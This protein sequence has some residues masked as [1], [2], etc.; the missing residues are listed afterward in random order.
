MFFNQING[1]GF[2][3]FLSVIFRYGFFVADMSSTND[4]CDSYAVMFNKINKYFREEIVL[5]GA[6]H[7][8][9]EVSLL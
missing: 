4:T 6:E 5:D 3:F 2:Y 8:S 1:D 9:K 7:A